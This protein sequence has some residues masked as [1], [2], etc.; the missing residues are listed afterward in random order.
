MVS[1]VRCALRLVISCVLLSGGCSALLAASVQVKAPFEMPAIELPRIPERDF[2]ITD[3]GAVQGSGVKITQ[4][5]AQAIAACHNAGGGRVIIP[6]GRWLTGA[7]HLKSRVNLHLSE[8]AVLEFS[9]APADYLPAVSTS[10]E[11]MECYNY[12]PLIYALECE[13]VA[14]TGS[15]TLE[16]RL[17][18]WKQWYARPPAHMQALKQLYEWMSAGVPIE[19]RQMAVGENNLR[20]HFVQF[21]R[22]QR[23]LLEDLNI[24][25]SPFWT[26]H[27]YLCSDAVIRRANISA[28]GHNNDGV[29]PEMTRNLLVEDC[30]FDQGDD[31]IAIKAGRNHDGWRVGVPTENIVM[32][33]CV[34]KRGHQLVAI[35][36]E[37]SAGIRNVYVH[38]CRFE[39]S[40]DDKPQHILF[41][42]TNRRRGGFVENIHVENIQA[43]STRIGV[44]GIE[45]D[46]LYQWRNLV[47]T[48]VEKL[49]RI[50][51]IHF[52]N[53]SVEETVTPFRILG[54]AE[55]PI[56]NV[57]IENVSIRRVTGD[58]T[59]YRNVTG[60]REGGI[61]VGEVLR[62]QTEGPT[63]SP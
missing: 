4:A 14:L 2:V 25:N 27:L 19:K 51:N 11:G 50:Q 63:R 29:D 12:S 33:R 15:G 22:C 41:I 23:I 10:W 20:P 57:S 13:D 43:N 9:D 42:K 8:G 37:L 62:P 36:S 39:N 26:I 16:A 3:F 46:V 61:S 30:V 18:T 48:Y 31:A 60:L 53:V 49:T 34:M 1:P 44:L 54:D 56:E 28:L 58:L 32:R 35:G 55:L 24:R 40:P 45:T 47:P 5:I 7:V 17:G 21:Q 59:Q 38:D 52:K 6:P